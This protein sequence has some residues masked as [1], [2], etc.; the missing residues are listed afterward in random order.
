MKRCLLFFAILFFSVTSIYSHRKPEIKFN[1]DDV[2]DLQEVGAFIISEKD[3]IKVQFVAPENRRLNAYQDVD[4]KKDDIIM[5]VN[6]KAVMK[7]NDLRET[8]DKLKVGKDFKLEIKRG[9]KLMTVSLKKADPKVLPPKRMA[10]KD[11]IRWVND[12]VLL[13]GYRSE[14]HTSELQSPCNLVC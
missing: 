3:R 5:M 12:K 4:L 14:E 10:K 6:G 8:Y 9:G 11:E 13:Q 2:Y 1:S 7:L